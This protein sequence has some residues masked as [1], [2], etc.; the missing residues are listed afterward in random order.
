M[1]YIN[2]KSGLDIDLG[3]LSPERA[4]LF[5]IARKQFQ[6][7]VSWFVFEQ[8][9]FSY[10]SPLFKDLKTRADVVNDPL[11]TALKDMWL[12]LGIKQGFVAAPD[13]RKQTKARPSGPHRSSR[14][15]DVETP[16]QPAAARR[17]GR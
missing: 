12:Q 1:H 4:R 11:F 5:D 7:N 10:T 17:R 14:E 2:P 6:K 8:L 16:R 3:D 9:I 13:D 15:R